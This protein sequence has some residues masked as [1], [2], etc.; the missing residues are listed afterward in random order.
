MNGYLLLTNPM[1]LDELENRSG[2]NP[3]SQLN[4]HDASRR[5]CILKGSG[6]SR[7]TNSFGQAKE[8]DSQLRWREYQSYKFHDCRKLR[9]L[10]AGS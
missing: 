2:N 1:G 7:Q 4:A 10:G 8:L 9:A 3:L 5:N 6:S